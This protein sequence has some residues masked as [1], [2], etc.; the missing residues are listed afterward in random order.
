[1]ELLSSSSR[2][3]ATALQNHPSDAQ[4]IDACTTGDLS[5]VQILVHCHGIRVTARDASRQVTPLH[6]ACAEGHAAIVAWIVE[7]TRLM[8]EYHET[9]NE[10]EDTSY[11]EA[12]PQNN[13]DSYDDDDC[14]D[15]DNFGGGILHTNDPLLAPSVTYLLQATDSAGNTPLHYACVNGHVPIVRMLAKAMVHDVEGWRHVYFAQNHHGRT[16]LE[17]AQKTHKHAI[18]KELQRWKPPPE[19]PI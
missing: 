3:S 9:S 5:R 1:M 13:T 8:L 6:M 4:L 14:D 15:D 18:V 7:W 2:T 17:W 16:P 12:I 10:H 19:R 11:N